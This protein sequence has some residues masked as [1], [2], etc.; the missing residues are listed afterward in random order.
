MV[1]V[2]AR[3]KFEEFIAKVGIPLLC[4][5]VKRAG[6]YPDD[7]DRQEFVLRKPEDLPQFLKLLDFEYEAEWYWIHNGEIISIGDKFK[8]SVCWFED[9]SWGEINDYESDGLDY[10]H[11]IHRS[12][13]EIPSSIVQK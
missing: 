7:S 9:G 1:K 2:N 11:W 10:Y 3:V 12:R 5:V 6:Y 4:A 13:P 8:E